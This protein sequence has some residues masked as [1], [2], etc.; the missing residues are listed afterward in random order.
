MANPPWGQRSHQ[1]LPSQASRG[2]APAPVTPAGKGSGPKLTKLTVSAFEPR[3]A[4]TAVG[5]LTRHTGASVLT[6]VV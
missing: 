1:S 5:M 4:V 2:Q 3:G 6:G